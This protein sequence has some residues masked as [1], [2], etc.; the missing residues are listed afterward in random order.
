MATNIQT[1]ITNIKREYPANI[2]QI[3]AK[4]KE[5]NPSLT[6]SI[7]EQL[8]L[9]FSETHIRIT[10]KSSSTEYEGM[11]TTDSYQ[12]NLVLEIYD[13]MAGPLTYYIYD[14]NQ[15]ANVHENNTPNTWIV[16]T[17]NG[18]RTFT[19]ATHFLKLEFIDRPSIN[20]IDNYFLDSTGYL[21]NSNSIHIPVGITSIGNYFLSGCTNFNQS[22]ILPIG[23]I[24]IGNGFMVSCQK[25]NQM[26]A[27]PNSVT[28]IGDNFMFNCENYNKPLTLSNSLTS[29][30]NGFMS[31]CSNFNEQ[32]ILPNSLTSIGDNFMFNCENY[33][34]PLILP[35]S[36]TSIGDNFMFNLWHFTSKL[37]IPIEIK[38][39][40]FKKEN[41]LSFASRVENSPL[42]FNIAYVYIDDLIEKFPNGRFT[43]NLANYYRNIVGVQLPQTSFIAKETNLSYNYILN[44]VLGEHDIRVY[45]TRENEASMKFDKPISE[46]LPDTTTGQMLI[47]NALNT[48]PENELTK[49]AIENKIVS[50]KFFRK[51]EQQ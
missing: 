10:V 12:Y 24:S 34:K 30:G 16:M 8:E 26:L 21:S 2:N 37:T 35:N 50:I 48:L 31:S 38:P 42:N 40:M 19:S 1:I 7:I 18:E 32:L 4:L 44:F 20:H 46:I 9:V 6:D 3:W 15:L 23:L 49:S 36:L 51:K 47:G 14:F 25:F 41:G 33:N 17:S 43:Y 45:L 22:L 11:I 28:S 27:I 29:I 5:D 13:D 39:E